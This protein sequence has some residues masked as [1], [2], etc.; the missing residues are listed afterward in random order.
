MILFPQSSAFTHV[1][2]EFEILYRTIL[3]TFNTVSMLNQRSP[4]SH[5]RL[6]GEGAHQL[7]GNPRS[8]ATR[9]SSEVL[10]KWYRGAAIDVVGEHG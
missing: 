5:Y 1:L 10:V 3:V 7:N 8:I 4:Q 2:R 6:A 9:S